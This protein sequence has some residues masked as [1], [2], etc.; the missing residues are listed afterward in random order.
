VRLDHDLYRLDHS[1]LRLDHDLYRLDRSFVRLGR[2]ASCTTRRPATLTARKVRSHCSA[3]ISCSA[4]ILRTPPVDLSNFGAVSN[5]FFGPRHA[6]QAK[7]QRFETAP[8]CL[9]GSLLGD[10]LSK[11]FRVVGHICR[12]VNRWGHVGTCEWL[13]VVSPPSR[14][15]GVPRVASASSAWHA[16]R[17]PNTAARA[18]YAATTNRYT[19]L[20]QRL[21]PV[22]HRRR[23][24]EQKAP[25]RCPEPSVADGDL[26]GATAGTGAVATASGD[27]EARDQCATLATLDEADATSV[28]ALRVR[29]QAQ[30][31]ARNQQPLPAGGSQ[32]SLHGAP[33]GAAHG[34]NSQW[35]P[36]DGDLCEAAPAQAERAR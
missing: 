34:R 9:I 16:S 22:R 33:R 21:T 18:G 35:H 30:A 14:D 1:F 24:R 20:P 25:G 3:P 13:E 31:K 11:T 15:Q 17:L 23:R 27:D 4:S 5:G 6:R 26:V 29:Q 19:P 12:L 32:P 36:T 28:A 8:D 7:P 10:H 2:G